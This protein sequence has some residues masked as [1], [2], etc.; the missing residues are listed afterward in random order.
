[1]GRRAGRA[2]WSGASGCGSTRGALNSGSHVATG[3]S[4][5]RAPS[6]TRRSVAAAVTTFVIDWMRKTASGRS[7]APSGPSRP[8]ANGSSS[9]KT[10]TAPGIVPAVTW[11]ASRPRRLSDT[12]APSVAGPGAL[13]LARPADLPAVAAVQGVRDA[14]EALEVEGCGLA[15]H[16]GAV[17]EVELVDVDPRRAAL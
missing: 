10:P 5:P 15:P 14:H 3:S 12:R 2:S 13:S 1:M 17:H 8:T 6:C 7:A 9:P 11:R 16:S 4:S